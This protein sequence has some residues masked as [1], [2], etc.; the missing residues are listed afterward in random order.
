MDGVNDL[1][2]HLLVHLTYY[3]D[4][5]VMIYISFTLIDSIGMHTERL[6]ADSFNFVL[7]KIIKNMKKI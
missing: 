5:G 7:I 2:R 4:I 3:A 1:G 6:G